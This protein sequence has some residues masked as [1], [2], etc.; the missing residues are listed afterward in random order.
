MYCSVVLAREYMRVTHAFNSCQSQ[1]QV[2]FQDSPGGGSSSQSPQCSKF[3]LHLIATRQT[4]KKMDIQ[5]QRSR[6]RNFQIYIPRN[7]CI[8]ICSL[9]TDRTRKLRQTNHWIFRCS[10]NKWNKKMTQSINLNISTL[11]RKVASMLNPLTRLIAKYF[12][13]ETCN[14]LI[15]YLVVEYENV[16]RNGFS[17]RRPHCLTFESIW[18]KVGR[19]WP[20]LCCLQQKYKCLLRWKLLTFKGAPFPTN[21]KYHLPFLE[22]WS[23]L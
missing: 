12:I 19:K 7:T 11:R 21:S 9:W 13:S 8:N 1:N 14:L 23:L 18:H 6:K 5:V 17:L 3:N 4:T 2:P 20:L 16:W 22:S 10:D 15:L